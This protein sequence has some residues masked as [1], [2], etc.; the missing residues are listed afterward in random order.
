MYHRK[1]KYTQFQYVISYGKYNDLMIM[2]KKYHIYVIEQ[3][4]IECIL[5]QKKAHIRRFQRFVTKL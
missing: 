1:I 3:I 4:K 5:M 2:R